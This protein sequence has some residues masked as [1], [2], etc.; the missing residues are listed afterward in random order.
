M[1]TCDY[2]V[3]VF[4]F[5]KQKTAYEMRISDWSSDVC[6]SDLSVDSLWTR[7]HPAGPEGREECL[8]HAGAGGEGDETD[9]FGPAHCTIC[10][11]CKTF[12]TAFSSASAA[13]S[14]SG[15]T[16]VS[17]LSALAPT[18]SVPILPAR[19][20]RRGFS[21]SISRRM[22]SGDYTSPRLST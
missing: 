14:S 16:R 12:A 20:Q 8:F 11:R 13:M 21:R 7:Q 19:R 5:F 3:C 2:L 22:S 15:L 18:L 17:T 4:F 10:P 9:E 6:S 1:C